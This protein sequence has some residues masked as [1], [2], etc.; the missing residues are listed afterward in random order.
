[1]GQ[2]LPKMKQSEKDTK[3]AKKIEFWVE[4]CP[5]T[6]YCMHT[7]KKLEDI[8]EED[9]II[10][11]TNVGWLVHMYVDKV[12]KEREVIVL[13]GYFL[14]NSNRFEAQADIL[15][16]PSEQINLHLQK[17]E[18]SMSELAPI[19]EAGRLCKKTYEQQSTSEEQK[20][21]LERMIREKPA[22]ALITNNSEHFVSFVKTGS[23][24]SHQFQPLVAA[25]ARSTVKS[26]SLVAFT[27]TVTEKGAVELLREAAVAMLHSGGNVTNAYVNLAVEGV[28]EVAKE[29]AKQAATEAA[30][31]GTKEIVKQATNSLKAAAKIGGIIEV[32]FFCVDVGLTGYQWFNGKI[33]TD[34]FINYAIKRAVIGLGSFVGGLLGGWVGAIIGGLIGS[35]VPVIGTV[36][37]GYIGYFIGSV[38]GSV[39]ASLVARLGYT[40][41][42]NQVMHSIKDKTE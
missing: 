10:Y 22:F 11:I 1:M 13:C 8:K 26:I 40:L 21:R 27:K 19:V 28:K 37:G 4:Q 33:S 2:L 16:R 12:I 38:F 29:G 34:Q 20:K 23:R 41:T 36:I 17:R 24:E 42:A 39:T 35:A 31:D 9:H 18:F 32:I 6:A 7:I 14:D 25:A 30:K 15:I 5:D 3:W